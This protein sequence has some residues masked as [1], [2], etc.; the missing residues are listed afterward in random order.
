M[1]KVSA[2]PAFPAGSPCSFAR[3]WR[4]SST[5]ALYGRALAG[6]EAAAGGCNSA[7]ESSRTLEAPRVMYTGSFHGGFCVPL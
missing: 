6:C 3:G 5:T 7:P 4:A 2:T 1:R